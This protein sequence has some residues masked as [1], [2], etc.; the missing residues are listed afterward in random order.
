[1]N[2]IENLPL[3]KK[4][5]YTPT[6]D[7][8]IIG[9]CAIE[10]YQQLEAVCKYVKSI[11]FSTIRG[12]AY[13]HRTTPYKFS[14]LGQEG[15]EILHELGTKYGLTTVS[16]I[17]SPNQ[18][19]LFNEKVDVIMIGARNMRNYDLLKLVASI[20][21]PIILKRSMDSTLEDW[22]SACEHYL[23]HGGKKVIL[24]ER[25]VKTFDLSF[26]NMMDISSTAFIKKELDIPI[27]VDPSHGT[28][29]KPIMA[30]VT[31]SFLAIGCD[32]Y[33]VE[34]HPNPSSAL[35]DAE[36]ALS[37]FDFNSFSKEVI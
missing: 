30:L 31:K 21:K 12:G 13:K 34:I 9:P 17:T 11:G 29:Y 22:L 5:K 18:I 8:R 6:F 32:G 28:G 26:R 4:Y 35:C 36:Q 19:N 2:W 14:G 7:L 23:F 33:I 37:F 16:E 15:I 25:G 27:I 3:I 20:D 1:M 24:C 10:S